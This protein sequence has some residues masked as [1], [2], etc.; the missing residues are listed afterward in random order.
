M[1]ARSQLQSFRKGLQWLLRVPL[2]QREVFV[3]NDL[4]RSHD[5]MMMASHVNVL[6]AAPT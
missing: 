2:H 3:V 5:F 6:S 4:G 1:L